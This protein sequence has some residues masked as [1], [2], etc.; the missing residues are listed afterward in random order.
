MLLQQQ[1]ELP[2]MQTFE[3]SCIF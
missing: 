2:G 1:T 3:Q